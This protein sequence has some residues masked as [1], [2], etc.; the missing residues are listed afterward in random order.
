MKDESIALGMYNAR[1]R[2]YFADPRHAGDVA[3]G[4]GEVIRARA[5][6]S[7]TGAQVELAAVVTG[8]RLAALR[9]RAFG[10]PHLIAAA[11]ACCERFEGRPV[12][13]LHEFSIDWLMET[14][15]IPVEKTGRILLLEDA[16]ASLRTQPGGRGT[17]GVR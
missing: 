15:D 6:E 2:G 5:A 17:Q 1:V 9:F 4:A 8:G 16:I 7:D 14:L 3:A 10:C 11:E 13:A 12:E